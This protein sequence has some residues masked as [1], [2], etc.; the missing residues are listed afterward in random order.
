MSWG[1]G[2]SFI[3]TLLIISILVMIV[4]VFKN[5]TKSVPVTLDKLQ[6][7][8]DNV[9]SDGVNVVIPKGSLANKKYPVIGTLEMPTED[10]TIKVNIDCN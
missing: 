10:T 3:N 2:F 7:T 8:Y 5:V 1:F 6:K 4:L 9:C